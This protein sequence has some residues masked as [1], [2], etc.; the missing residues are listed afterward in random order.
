VVW[1]YSGV[2]PLL[3]DSAGASAVTRDYLL[4]CDDAGRPC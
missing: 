4:E 2:R 1:T 3:D